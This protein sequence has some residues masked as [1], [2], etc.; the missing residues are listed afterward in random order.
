M[1]EGIPSSYLTNSFEEMGLQPMLL[2][3][4]QMRSGL[5]LL[6]LVK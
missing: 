6:N 1:L 4:D 2:M 5:H 3:L